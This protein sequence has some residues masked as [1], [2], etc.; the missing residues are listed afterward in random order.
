MA[1]GS[2]YSQLDMI[3]HGE[4]VLGNVI[5][6]TTD[7]ELTHRGWKQMSD[8]CR[9]LADSG[10]KWDVCLT[11]PRKRCARF[12]RSLSKSMGIDCHARDEF[13]EVDFGRWEAMTFEEIHD[14]YPGQWQSWMS[15]PE[16]AAPHGGERYGDFLRRI[17]EALDSLLDEYSGRQMVLFA[18]GGVIRALLLRTLQLHPAALP[19][20]TIPHACHSR[21]RAYHR[22]GE[23]DWLCLEQHNSSGT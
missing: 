23:P 13:A 10:L 22:Q 3:R 12:A 1:D 4:H 15:N 21:I 5:C 18:H 14:R 16:H 6:G 11:S 2:P 19:R 7:P 17:A 20:F 8:R 9:K